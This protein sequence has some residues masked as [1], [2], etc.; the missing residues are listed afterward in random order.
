MDEHHDRIRR[1]IQV[2][3]LL[4]EIFLHNIPN[5][6]YEDINQ[7]DSALMLAEEDVKDAAETG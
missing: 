5:Q 6:R 3:L 7:V 1:L 2:Y 4:L